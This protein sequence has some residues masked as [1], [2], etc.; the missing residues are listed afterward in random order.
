MEI[1]IWTTLQC[2]PWG[3]VVYALPVAAISLWNGLGEGVLHKMGQTKGSRQEFIK[4]ADLR[5]LMVLTVSIQ[6]LG[7]ISPRY[8]SRISCPSHN[9]NL[10][11]YYGHF[12]TDSRSASRGNYPLH[13][14]TVWCRVGWSGCHWTSSLSGW[15]L[16]VLL[17][18]H[19]TGPAQSPTNRLIL[20]PPPPVS[21]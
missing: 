9:P 14:F 15:R 4:H 2:F 10:N 19:I 20:S 6:L 11:H 1:L 8:R 7:E 13:L 17:K 21:Y 3:L 12:K 5:R 16:N 18:E